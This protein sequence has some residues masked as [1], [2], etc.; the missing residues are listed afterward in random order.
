MN[1]LWRNPLQSTRLRNSVATI[2]RD[3]AGGF[4][5]ARRPVSGQKII[6]AP[7]WPNLEEWHVSNSGLTGTLPSSMGLSKLQT[8]DV[9]NN[10]LRGHV[11]NQWLENID[12]TSQTLYLNLANNRLEGFEQMT[13][14]KPSL[15]RFSKLVLDI[16]NNEMT[17]L[18]AGFCDQTGWMKGAV[19]KF[20][21][22]AIVCPPGYFNYQGR[23][24]SSMDDCQMCLNFDAS[25]FYGATTCNHDVASM[26][27]SARALVGTPEQ[28]I[29]LKALT[30]FYEATGGD[31][32][33]QQFG[34]FGGS[35]VCFWYGIS[36]ENGVVREIDL[37]NNNLRGITPES[38][39]QLTGL[40]RLIFLDNPELEMKFPSEFGENAT[41]PDL[42]G[43]ILART[44]TQHLSGISKVAPN[45]FLLDVNGAK[46]TGAAISE[47][48]LLTELKTL[49]MGDTALGQTLPTAIGDMTDLVS[50]R[51]SN[52]ILSGTIPSELRRLNKLV[53]LELSENN[54]T[55]SILSETLSP[56][57]D[58][59]VLDLH[60]QNLDG[61][62]PALNSLPALL[63]LDLS[64][65]SFSGSIPTTF[66]E[67]V[68]KLRSIDINLKSN[69]L[70]GSLPV[71]LA[72]FQSINLDV[73]EN[74]L[75]ELPEVFCAK[76]DWMFGLVEEF[77]CDAILCPPSTY[78]EY[79]RMI[80]QEFPC[81]NCPEGTAAAFGS[82]HCVSAD[83]NIPTLKPSSVL[84]ATVSPTTTP[85]SVLI[86]DSI[87]ISPS[88]LLAATGSPTIVSSSIV[89]VAS[90]SLTAASTETLMT[91]AAS[92]ITTNSPTAQ[93]LTTTCPDGHLC[94][95][96]GRCIEIP[97]SFG[98]YICDC[99]SITE[100]IPFEGDECQYPATS[101]C[102]V[103]PP[104]TSF[105]VNGGACVSLSPLAIGHSPCVCQED[106][107]GVHCEIPNP[108]ITSNINGVA[109]SLAVDSS[110]DGDGIEEWKMTLVFVLPAL[111][112]I[113]IVGLIIAGYRGRKQ[114]NMKFADADYLVDSDHDKCNGNGP[115]IHLQI[116]DL[117]NP[118]DLSE[119][120]TGT[121]GS[122]IARALDCVPNET[123]ADRPTIIGRQDIVDGVE[124]EEGHTFSTVNGSGKAKMVEPSQFFGSPESSTASSV[125]TT[126]PSVERPS[127]NLTNTLPNTTLRGA[128]NEYLALPL[129]S[130]GNG[131]SVEINEEPS[132]VPSLDRVASDDDDSEGDR[133]NNIL[134]L[135][136]I[137]EEEIENI[138]F[139]EMAT[140]EA[141][142]SLF[143]ESEYST[144]SFIGDIIDTNE[145]TDTANGFVSA[146]ASGKSLFS[147]VQH[148]KDLS[149]SFVERS[150]GMSDDD[151]EQSSL[152][153]DGRVR[154]S[155][156][157]SLAQSLFGG[158][159]ASE[160]DTSGDLSL[161]F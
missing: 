122:I 136:G 123:L 127:D 140:T 61:A 151:S 17:N 12:N 71:E 28:S 125:T 112:I 50:L 137:R 47:V 76:L 109:N 119:F 108:A 38:L 120:G 89:S 130:T 126:P 147:G 156:S 157:P 34:W 106:F 105:C 26:A 56:M 24:T 33:T 16:A 92:E 67:D 160:T 44:A 79:G 39:F 142:T 159:D 13:A 63:Q 45:L 158:R 29:Q 20:G 37:P 14:S 49:N 78:N 4:K 81:L 27:M 94:Q 88:S 87:T 132:T 131:M 77:E 116:S 2:I 31:E 84:S 36:C 148:E 72:S 82:V 58:L 155:L 70:T 57:Q 66:L 98:N 118:E 154:L 91:S 25:I 74:L 6:Y 93:N 128:R 95:N 9:S 134:E 146:L 138:S 5:Q 99:Q 121:P 139:E 43:L 104:Y 53:I 90:E 52:A 75:N 55:G 141:A 161:N 68:D 100:L 54:F 65:N 73:T 150:I 59:R 86:D 110:S 19:R 42:Q 60:G 144:T 51:I 143:E 149:V 124:I 3:V 23:Q 133:T 117:G 153:E 48:L 1:D 113:T 101:L 111:V 30:E 11:P 96:G 69:F 18:P 7:W 83:T 80:S 32:W 41:L 107:T 129:H 40:R 35:N 135:S 64:F 152:S 8:L 15:L 10:Q 22:N 46:I 145:S 115:D 97:S 85:S 103:D 114:N 62:L 102:S 21:C